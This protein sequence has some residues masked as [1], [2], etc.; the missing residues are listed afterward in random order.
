MTTPSYVI[1][2]PEQ[3]RALRSPVRQEIV[4]TV[5]SLGACSVADV[6]RE[7]GRH[8]DG[9]YYHVR[10]LV[11]VDLL[12]PAGTRSEG[13][14]SEALYATR[15]PDHP[16]RLRY[17]PEDP[18]NAEAVLGVVASMLRMTERDFAQAFRPDART[19]GP[20]RNLWA[21]RVKS[22]LS[23]EDLLEVNRL[24]GELEAIFERAKE[25]GRER[26]HAFTFVIAPIPARS[27]R[28]DGD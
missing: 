28:R 7:L 18:A 14:R 23:D 4:D 9:L 3:I 17:D 10:A 27:V 22:W 1:R 5:Q 16:M 2:R 21:A 25:P 26:L 12:R 24:L 20:S 15:S 13:G 11:R 6:A 8:A 19:E